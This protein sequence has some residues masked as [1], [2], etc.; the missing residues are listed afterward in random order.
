MYDLTGKVAVVTGA[1]SGIGRAIA[2]RLAGEGCDVGIV[3]VAASAEAAVEEVRSLGRRCSAVTADV[4][5]YTAVEAAARSLASEFGRIDILVNNA[6]VVHIERIVDMPIEAWRRVQAINSDGV[7]HCCKAFA[8]HIIAGGKGGRIVNVSSWLGK[9]GKAYYGA[10][11]ASKAAVIGL[12]QS[13]AQELAPYGITV[14]A[15]CPG[16]VID[17]GMRGDVEV[18]HAKYDLPSY[19]ERLPTIPLGRAGLPDDMARGVAFL[20]SEEAEYITGE[21]INLAGGVR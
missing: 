12:T 7:F 8:P 4:S 3:D 2:L 16:V 11:C 6:G 18:A 10:Y 1:A 9:T 21:A 20:I 19:E 13:L 5:D 14:N 17:T 15:I